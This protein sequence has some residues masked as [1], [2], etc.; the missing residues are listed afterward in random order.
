MR[1]RGW[2]MDP[3]GGAPVKGLSAQEY[4]K[5]LAAD[6][7][8][9]VS[10]GTEE[11]GAKPK[12]EAAGSSAARVVCTCLAEKAAPGV[13]SVDLGLVIAEGG[14]IRRVT[15]EPE[16]AVSACLRESLPH[17]QVAEPPSAPWKA[18]VRI[19]HYQ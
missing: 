14:E 19:L 10:A 12:P 9:C 18:K 5:L 1:S 4:S 15:A 13:T 2:K 11:T 6:L 16:S 7:T 17:A 8:I 3:N